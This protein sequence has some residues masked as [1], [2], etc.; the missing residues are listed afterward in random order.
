MSIASM[1]V[2]Y[3]AEKM[4]EGEKDRK[5]RLADKRKAELK[6]LREKLMTG[7]RDAVLVSDVTSY[8]TL[9]CSF[10]CLEIAICQLT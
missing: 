7:T 2:F 3:R 10:M 5:Q 1:H 8:H 4:W 6:N 9:L